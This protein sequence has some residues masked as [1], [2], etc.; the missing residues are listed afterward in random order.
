MYL[1]VNGL[2]FV[3]MFLLNIHSKMPSF[4][5]VINSRMVGEATGIAPAQ[6]P[7]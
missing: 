1:H 5:A 7:K 6:P 4:Q 3:I 2:Q